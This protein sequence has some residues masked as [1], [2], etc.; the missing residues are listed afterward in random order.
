ML[1][2]MIYTS[3]SA[4]RFQQKQLDDILVASRKNNPALQVTGLL[5]LKSGLFIQLLEGPRASVKELFAKISKDS[6][7]FHRYPRQPLAPGVLAL[8]YALCQDPM[9]DAWL[10]PSGR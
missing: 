1:Y 7:Q 10:L 3:A 6:S 8:G 5:M 9:A 2:T 4:K